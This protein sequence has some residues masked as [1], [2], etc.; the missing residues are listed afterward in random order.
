MPPPCAQ[1]WYGG[2]KNSKPRKRNRHKEL[3]NPKT[4]AEGTVANIRSF[5]DG[6]L[7]WSHNGPQNGLPG[8]KVICNIDFQAVG[9]EF[10]HRI[11]VTTV[12]SSVIIKPQPHFCLPCGRNETATCLSHQT[13]ALLSTPTLF[14]FTR[15]DQRRKYRFGQ[16]PWV[17]SSRPLDAKG[18]SSTR[19]T[20][21]SPGPVL[22]YTN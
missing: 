10:I 21:T 6:I 18:R 22:D 4:N 5:A 20:R 16:L 12:R 1:A 11:F 14:K 13:K 7:K 9:Q 15:A 19:K 17:Y 8:T 2:F 3:A